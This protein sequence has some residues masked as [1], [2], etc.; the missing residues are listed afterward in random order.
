MD[1]FDL[2]VYAIIVVLIVVFIYSIVLALLDDGPTYSPDKGSN[3]LGNWA[4]VN[5]D[6]GMKRSYYFTSPLVNSSDKYLDINLDNKTLKFGEPITWN[7][8][9]MRLSTETSGEFYYVNVSDY[10][11]I[12]LSKESTSTW[13]YDGYNFYLN[14]N[15]DI[16]KVAFLNPDTLQIS[17]IDQ[18]K[19][20]PYQQTTPN[21]RPTNPH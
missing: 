20:N 7:F 13:F 14:G 4:M 1:G 16:T 10:N 15:I 19:W 12:Y 9:G 21:W 11:S 8:D 2:M 6:R 18:K 3:S 5:T 17:F